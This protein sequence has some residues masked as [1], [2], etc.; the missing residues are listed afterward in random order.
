MSR[1]GPTSTRL[2]TVLLVLP[3]PLMHVLSVNR[4]TKHEISL[5]KRAIA[6]RSIAIMIHLDILATS[7]HFCLRRVLPRRPNSRCTRRDISLLIDELEVVSREEVWDSGELGSVACRVIVQLEERDSEEFHIF[8][9][10]EHFYR[11]VSK[12]T[13]NTSRTPERPR[14]NN[15]KKG[16]N[17]L[18]RGSWI[19]Y[20]F[21]HSFGLVTCAGMNGYMKVS[22]F[23]RHHC[24]RVSP[25]CH[26]SFTPWPVNCVPT[27]A[28]RS[29]SLALKPSTS[30]SS[31]RR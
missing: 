7:Q 25:T 28:R 23:G 6:P 8:R 17:I 11:L 1:H 4:N 13:T 27:G 24:A 30:S 21:L 16:S 9:D 12:H 29:F 20:N 2:S 10:A 31:A 14:M 22:K 18:L 3:T 5:R 15:T 26:S 19:K